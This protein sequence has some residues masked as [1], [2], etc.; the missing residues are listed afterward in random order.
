MKVLYARPNENSECKLKTAT[1]QLCKLLDGKG[2]IMD[3]RETVKCLQLN[4]SRQCGNVGVLPLGGTCSINTSNS[5]VKE[6]RRGLEGL[7]LVT[8][9]MVSRPGLS[10]LDSWTG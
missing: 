3:A 4:A 8:D 1:M 2:F 9:S 7:S 10:I 5:T 6:G